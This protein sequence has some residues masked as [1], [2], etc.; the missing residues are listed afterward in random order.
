MK[1]NQFS[2]ALTAEGSF[3]FSKTF[4]PWA[5]AVACSVTTDGQYHYAH[6]YAP[7]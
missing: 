6:P 5:L 4:G 7:F 2:R 3:P 1:T